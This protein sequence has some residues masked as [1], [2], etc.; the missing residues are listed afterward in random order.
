M[1]VARRHGG[2]LPVGKVGKK[3]LI[4]LPP[5]GAALIKKYSSYRTNLKKVPRVFFPKRVLADPKSHPDGW[6][7]LLPFSP[8]LS[9]SIS[10]KLPP[11]AIIA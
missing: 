7:T 10:S 9:T 3:V 6:Q 2:E 8:I 4:C 1:P 5:V 11:L